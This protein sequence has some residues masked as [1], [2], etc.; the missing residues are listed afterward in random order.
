MTLKGQWHIVV[1]GSKL[2]ADSTEMSA[3]LVRKTLCAS[4]EC[5]ESLYGE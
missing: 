4:I 3:V 1:G 5:T 2:S